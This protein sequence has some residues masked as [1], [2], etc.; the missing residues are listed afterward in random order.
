M[1]ENIR[2]KRCPFC[3]GHVKM[4]TRSGSL[5]YTKYYSIEHLGKCPLEII[6]TGDT[7]EE[8]AGKW[9]GQLQANW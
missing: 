3:G 9:N 1:G 6:C 2:L 5:T 4:V 8:T 7:P